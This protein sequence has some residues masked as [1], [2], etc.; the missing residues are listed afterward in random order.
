ML[1]EADLGT[2]RFYR[3]ERPARSKRL[4]KRVARARRDWTEHMEG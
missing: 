2:G 1:R 4:E 3:S